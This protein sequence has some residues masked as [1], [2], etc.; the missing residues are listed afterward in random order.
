VVVGLRAGAVAGG[1][2]TPEQL[3]R[4]RGRAGLPAVLPLGPDDLERA[5][6]VD[7]LPGVYGGVG[8]GAPAQGRVGLLLFMPDRAVRRPRWRPATPR[9]APSILRWRPTRRFRHM[10]PR[11][12]E[13]IPADSTASANGGM[14]GG[15]LWIDGDR[16]RPPSLRLPRVV[17]R[18]D[19]WP[20]SSLAT[21]H[22]AWSE[23]VCQLDRE[24][25]SVFRCARFGPSP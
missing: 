15:A 20:D 8:A 18:P 13:A 21:T 7:R 4:G 9:S 22:G 10:S 23:H 6:A 5:A 25:R 2:L 3:G 16:R 14:P 19:R 12:R 17:A 11:P 1:S 24:L